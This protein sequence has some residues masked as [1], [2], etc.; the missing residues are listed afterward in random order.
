MLTY[1]DDLSDKQQLNASDLIRMLLRYRNL[2]GLHASWE[3]TED[4]NESLHL[5]YARL[6][7]MSRALGYDCTPLEIWRGEFNVDGALIQRDVFHSLMQSAFT[8]T[9]Q[10]AKFCVQPQDPRHR[11]S[12]RDVTNAWDKHLELRQTLYSIE[13]FNDGWFANPH[14]YV[15]SCHASLASAEIRERLKEQINALDQ[16]LGYLLDPQQRSFSLE[17]LC[18]HWGWPHDEPETDVESLWALSDAVVSM[19]SQILDEEQ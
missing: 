17:E 6:Q 9:E 14:G 1:A 10:L 16:A 8:T 13:I 15:M 7:A 5:Q 4:D 11:F 19:A 12:M 18:S 2:K 3:P